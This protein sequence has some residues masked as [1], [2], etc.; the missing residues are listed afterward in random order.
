MNFWSILGIQPTNNLKDIKR[1]YAKQ[2]KVYHPEDDPKNSNACKRLIKRPL[3]G[4]N[5]ILEMRRR[6]PS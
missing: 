2:S 6:V 4:K 1:A 5:R 3:P